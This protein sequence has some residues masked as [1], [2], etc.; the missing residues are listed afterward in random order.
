[1]PQPSLADEQLEW[2]WQALTTEPAIR[3]ELGLQILSRDEEWKTQEAVT[4][5]NKGEALGIFLKP[6]KALGTPVFSVPSTTEPAGT[7]KLLGILTMGPGKATSRRFE[8]RDVNA[9][10]E[11]TVENAGSLDEEAV[12]MKLERKDVVVQHNMV[13]AWVRSL[14]HA[15]TVTSRRLQANRRSHGGRIYDHIAWRKN[16]EWISLEQIRREVEA[17]KWKMP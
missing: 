10:V 16:N 11:I 17:G 2:L 9:T 13:M 3:R 5:L 8:C 7:I 12:L 1:M 15:F 4:V 14:N 6:L